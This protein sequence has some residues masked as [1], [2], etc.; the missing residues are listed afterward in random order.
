MIPTD[1]QKKQL[2]EFEELLLAWNKTHSLV[3]KSQTKKIKEHI[4]DSLSVS[5]LLGKNILD[6]GSGGGFPGLPLA[7]TNPRKT[8][9]LVEK[10]QSKAS[11]L[12]N[13][14]NII[15][16]NNTEVFNLDSEK[17]IPQDFQKPLEIIV[18]AFG[19]AQKTIFA[20]SKLLKSSNACLKLMKTSPFKEEN[21]IP[22]GYRVSKIENVDSKEKDKGRI[23]VTIVS[24]KKCTQ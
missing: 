23:L 3:S 2:K 15:G 10:R 5:H 12:L 16:L 7:I 11:F 1:K 24:K 9:Y 13:T 4:K 19:T 22:E 14:V 21:N 20:V 6:L 8:F 18:R 17:L